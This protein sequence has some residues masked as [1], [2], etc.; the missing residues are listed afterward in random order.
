MPRK[1][2]TRAA[3]PK[4]RRTG[5][6]VKRGAEDQATTQEFEREGMGVAAKE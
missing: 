5:K 1:S 4:G 6:P 2:P 3:V